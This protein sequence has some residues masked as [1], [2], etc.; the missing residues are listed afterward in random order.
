M[1][2]LL[3]QTD[4]VAASEE[5]V[6]SSSIFVEMLEKG[7]LPAL[8]IFICFTIFTLIL[9]SK[10]KQDAA[11]TEQLTHMT[12]AYEK[13]VHR[14]IDLTEDTTRAV[15]L[16]SERVHSCPFRATG[17]PKREEEENNE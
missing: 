3:A 16:V 1:F 8:A 6:E 5:A 12:S 9:K 7:G 10:A 14:F 13:L 11:V 2:N 15:T 17:A 4:P